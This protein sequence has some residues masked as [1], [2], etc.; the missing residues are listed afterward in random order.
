VHIDPED[1][2]HLT[3]A[4]DLP[5]RSAVQAQLKS[6][7]K[8]IDAATQIERITLH[9][10]GGRLRIELLL[11]LSVLANPDTGRQ[12]AARSRRPSPKIH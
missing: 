2:T 8:D 12:L 6:R 4:R 9:Y 10:V 5:S 1:D 3:P 11:P 7:F